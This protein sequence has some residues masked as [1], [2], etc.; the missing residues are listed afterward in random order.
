MKA[1]TIYKVYSVLWILVLS[2]SIIYYKSNNLAS[3]TFNGFMIIFLLFMP[4]G[5]SLNQSGQQSIPIKQH[6]SFLKHE[7]LFNLRKKFLK[8]KNAKTLGSFLVFLLA[9][10]IIS[11]WMT[12]FILIK[13]NITLGLYSG[14]KVSQYLKKHESV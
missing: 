11:P 8:I 5:I 6:K 4:L 7:A 2:Y 10:L 14:V 3:I 1:K 13:F 12:Y 9:H